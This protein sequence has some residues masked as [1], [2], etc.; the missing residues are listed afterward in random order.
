MAKAS[1][2]ARKSSPGDLSAARF[3]ELERHIARRMRHLDSSAPVGADDSD[4]SQAVERMP[5]PELPG[6]E[7]EASGDNTLNGEIEPIYR[8]IYSSYGTRD[9]LLGAVNRLSADLS[10]QVDEL[11][12][13]LA[14]LEERLGV[15]KQGL[16]ED[17][18]QA[19]LTLAAER[20]PVG[21]LARQMLALEYRL[22]RQTAELKTMLQECQRQL[23][24]QVEDHLL[25]LERLNLDSRDFISRNLINLAVVLMIIL[26]AG[27]FLL[28]SSVERMRS[29]VTDRLEGLRENIR[30]LYVPAKPPMAEDKGRLSQ[31]AAETPA[32]PHSTG[33]SPVTTQT[34]A[35]VP[36]E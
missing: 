27:G 11:L 1:R 3:Q 20:S 10:T 8:R 34:P 23:G 29:Y 16:P 19:R 15:S 21:E 24:G 5:D 26:F 12:N 6:N 33:K 17:E 36:G 18:S 9:E 28:S 7:R 32:T 4:G 2:Q 13:R 25:T 30:T 31:Q 14:G 22:D 35:S